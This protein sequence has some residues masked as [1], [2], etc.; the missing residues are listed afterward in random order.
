MQSESKVINLKYK[1]S[2]L[3]LYEIALTLLPGVGDVNA[4]KLVAYCGGAEAVFR[5]RRKNLLQ[6]PGIGE[7]T[8]DSIVS[9]NVL[10]RAEREL[11]FVEKNNI[12]IL[13]YLNP[14]YPKRLQHC[15]DSPVIIYCKGETDL[16]V[17]KIIGVVGTRNVTDYGKYLTDK[18]IEELSEDD[19]LVVSGLAYGVDTCA[20]KAALKN[21]LKTAAV[22]AHGFHTL[23]PQ[24]NLN[25]SRKIISSGGCLLTENISGV[26][27]DRENFPKRN[28][29]VAG[30]IDCLIVV[31]SA[32]KGGALITAEI[33]NSYDRDVFALPGRIGDAFSEGCN[34]LI[35]N[36]KASLLANANDIR[37]V[38]RWD[39]DA[40]IKPKQLKMFREFNEDEKLIMN[41]FENND[42]INLDDIIIETR[43]SPSKIASILLSLEFDGI[44]KAL[45]GKRY[46][47]L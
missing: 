31:E 32:S 30:M 40:K 1:M 7:R 11:L 27:P 19:V 4:K 8:V 9:Q 20:H 41:L 6:I 36:N 26:E 3:L 33:A 45:P 16:N 18:I 23:Y 28:R 2:D 46:Q 13:Y 37:Y 10:S 43:L 24:A 5:E 47:K 21:E 15:Y 29:I 44:V 39:A 38:M 25:L 14:D 35:K 34:N 12:R 17:D 22:L 42:M